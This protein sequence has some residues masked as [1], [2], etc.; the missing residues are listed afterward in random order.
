MMAVALRIVYIALC[1]LPA[2]LAVTAPCGPLLPECT[3]Y[4]PLYQ[5][6]YTAAEAWEK[7]GGITQQHLEAAM[8]TIAT[9]EGAYI[10][11]VEGQAYVRIPKNEGFGTRLFGSFH[12]LQRAMDRLGRDNFPGVQ[13]G[14]L[15]S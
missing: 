2:A 3:K 5:P 11:I 15:P 12:L 14:R 9:S 1:C 13:V 8:K 4:E 6:V 7:A 10:T